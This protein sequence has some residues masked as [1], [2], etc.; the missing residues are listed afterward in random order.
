MADSWE[1]EEWQCVTAF[2]FGCIS[3]AICL[4]AIICIGIMKQVFSRLKMRF[5]SIIDGLGTILCPTIGGVVVGIMSWVC[6]LVIGDGNM[7]LGSI[8]KF[9]ALNLIST[10]TL[11]TSAFAKMLTLAISMNCGFIGGFAFPM[12]TIGAICGVVAYQQYSYLPLG[13]CLGCFLAGVPAGICPMPFTLIGIPIYL[14]YF[15]VYQTIPIF[16]CAI[17]SYTVVCGSGLFKLLADRGK[18]ENKNNKEIINNSN[19]NN[20]TPNDSEASLRESLVRQ[21]QQQQ[22]EQAFAVS[23]YKKKINTNVI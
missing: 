20:I 8:V 6:P 22:E 7:V 13:L 12:L 11:I 14:L 10:H 3:G 21:Q 23:H 1:F 17:T 9:G 5:N 15:G 16:I 19:I 4:T 2:I 18:G